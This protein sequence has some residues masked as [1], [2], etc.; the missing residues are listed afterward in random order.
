MFAVTLG[1]SRLFPNSNGLT[2]IIK[3]LSLS[4]AP[5]PSLRS[6]SFA[7]TLLKLNSVGSK[8]LLTCWRSWGT[9]LCFALSGFSF[10]KE[11]NY[12]IVLLDKSR[13]L[14][15]SGMNFKHE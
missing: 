12:N 7:G 1:T 5:T 3:T 9:R 11:V 14:V 10:K 2:F 15:A 8:G 6:I 4:A 13:I